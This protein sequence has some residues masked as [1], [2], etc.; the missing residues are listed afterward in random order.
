MSVW[1][2]ESIARQICEALLPMFVKDLGL[3]AYTIA[4]FYTTDIRYCSNDD[5]GAIEL[6]CH[7]GRPDDTLAS[8]I[9]LNCG[10]TWHHVKTK[11]PGASQRDLYKS[12]ILS[13]AGTFAHE[14]R[15]AWQRKTAFNM[16]R[17]LPYWERPCEVDARA[18]ARSESLHRMAEIVSLLN[19]LG[20][21]LRRAHSH[22]MGKYIDL[23]EFVYRLN[24]M[25]GDEWRYYLDDYGHWYEPDAAIV[26]P[27]RLNI[28]SR[29]WYMA[30]GGVPP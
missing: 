4:L 17:E 26:R 14:M 15:H 21:M 13:L 2:C 7:Y 1:I 16:S 25:I 5:G 6:G 10:S 11:Y 28:C 9:M 27:Y 24:K 18:W 29:Q 30:H 20:G 3:E 23:A 8:N 19:D 12:F 22:C